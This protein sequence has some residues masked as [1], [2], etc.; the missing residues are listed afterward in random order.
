M[1]KHF[2]LTATEAVNPWG[3]E[4]WDAIPAFDSERLVL[5]GQ[6]TLI[7]MLMIFAVLSVLWIVLAISK[8]IFAKPTQT[9]KPAPA[10]KAA[11]SPKVAPAPAAPS[12]A[13]TNDAELVA[14]L[15]A[16]VAAYMASENPNAVST[17]A[18]RVVSYRRTNGGRP[19]NTK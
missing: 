3:K 2:A 11:P 19:W 6:V 10:P 12:P 16:A 15:T 14:V 9:A 13:S 7:G 1:I 4:V 8:Q 17:T 18:F 5:A